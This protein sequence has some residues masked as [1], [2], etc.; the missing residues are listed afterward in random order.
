MLEISLFVIAIIATALLL[1]WIVLQDDFNSL[2]GSA[3]LVNQGF[4]NYSQEVRKINQINRSV[5]MAGQNFTSV[6]DNLLELANTIPAGIKLSSL[7]LDRPALKLILSGTAKDRN[8]LLNYQEK[9]KEVSW[10]E[11]IDTPASQ[12]LQKE[13]INFEFTITLKKEKK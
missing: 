13:T 7:N 11:K 2:S 10:V 3:I 1:S 5:V 6:T 8:D 9:I 4:S 12:I